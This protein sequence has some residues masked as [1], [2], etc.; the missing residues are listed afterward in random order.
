M[1]EG[2]SGNGIRGKIWRE[3]KCKGGNFV[4]RKEE[5]C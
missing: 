1:G 2:I 4:K 5:K 3:E